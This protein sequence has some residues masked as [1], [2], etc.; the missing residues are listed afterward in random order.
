MFRADFA[1]LLGEL[2]LEGPKLGA[3]GVHPDEGLE[4]GDFAG[5]DRQVRDESFR[6][7]GF[8]LALLGGL[9]LA[10]LFG[11]G[12][13]VGVD[14]GLNVTWFVL[15]VGGGWVGGAVDGRLEDHGE[16]FEARVIHDVVE[17]AKTQEACADV[18]VEVAFAAAWG[19]GV[20]E[21]QGAEV[22]QT[23]LVFELLHEGLVACWRG[24]VVSCCEAVAGIYAD[25]D[26][27]VML[28]RD[29][30]EEVPELGE[31]AAN[32]GAMA[33]HRLKDGND[34]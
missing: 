17:G 31:V 1:A 33:A 19:L 14:V 34:G 10:G 9:F 12:C 5:P 6:A 25:A 30:G 21:V 4:E 23:D 15:D 3:F 27:G 24:E 22:L 13:R 8:G 7:S 26:A 29:Q 28:A 20:V 11:L 2:G 18:G 32:C 16:A